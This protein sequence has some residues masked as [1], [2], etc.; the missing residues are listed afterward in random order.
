MCD[1]PLQFEENLAY[2]QAVLRHSSRKVDIAID[3]LVSQREDLS[4]LVYSLTGEY[5]VCW[6]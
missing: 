5:R 2:S 1:A 6:W 3:E 4:N